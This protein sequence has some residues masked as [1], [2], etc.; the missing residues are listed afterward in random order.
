[1]LTECAKLTFGI[2]LLHPF[3]LHLMNRRGLD[4]LFAPAFV[5]VPA[6]VVLVTAITAAI[7]FVISKIPGLRKLI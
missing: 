5:S 1:M 3:V 2:Y 7:V 6:V 4:T